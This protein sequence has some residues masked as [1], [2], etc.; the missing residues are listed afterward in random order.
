MDSLRGIGG[1]VR[2]YP[3]YIT[4]TLFDES[5][6]YLVVAEALSVVYSR[7]Q[8]V[9][10][11]SQEL[12]IEVN[13]VR[14]KIPGITKTL[15]YGQGA[16]LYGYLVQI[17]KPRSADALSGAYDRISITLHSSETGEMGMGEAF[18]KRP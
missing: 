8:C 17:T 9:S 4:I 12:I 18:I 5:I 15:E 2:H 10:F 16:Y 7:L 13:G 1:D 14:V 3:L 11:V 6:D